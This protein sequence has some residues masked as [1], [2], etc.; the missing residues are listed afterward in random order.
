MLLDIEPFRAMG[1][2]AEARKLESEGRSI[3]HLELGEPS[4][5]LP[6]RVQDAA[7][8][9]M[10]IGRM[11]YTQALGLPELRQAIA[12]LYWL[13]HGL[14][15]EPKRIAVTTGSSAGFVLAFKAAFKPGDRIGIPNPGYPAYRNILKAVGLVP[16]PIE[17]PRE[18]DYVLTKEHVK[19]AHSEGALAGL[20]VMSPANPTGITMSKDQL[21]DLIGFCEGNGIRFVS[22]EIY[23]GLVAGEPAETALRFSSE[24]I[25]VNSFSKFHGMTGWRIGWLV[26]P[27]T[28]VDPVERLA[29]NLYLSPPTLSQI[30][31]LT[32]LSE[33]NYFENAARN[34]DASRALLAQ[35]LPDLG[36]LPWPGKGAFYVYC[37]ASQL[38]NDTEEFCRRA[39]HEAGVAMTPGLDFDPC[40]GHRYLRISFAGTTP[41]VVEG[42]ARLKRW[43]TT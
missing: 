15:L 38:T 30:V 21:R 34:Y 31:A 28:L 26:L 35:T 11:G 25:I 18:A 16:V 4:I 29:M 6:Q 36:L 12:A 3:I 8:E 20:L 41:N 27:D 37:D 14:D 33:H 1:V 24:A 5:A 23:H 9:A 43:L 39:L 13:R 22:D 2:L 10:R 7:S 19:A 17:T 40:N 32:A 42:L